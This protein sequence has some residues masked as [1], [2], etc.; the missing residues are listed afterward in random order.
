MI[1]ISQPLR[2]V[3]CQI[4]LGQSKVGILSRIDV[5]YLQSFVG[6]YKYT[7][8]YQTSATTVNGTVPSV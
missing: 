5:L 1:R 4:R 3:L 6:W 7:K 8:H 2:G